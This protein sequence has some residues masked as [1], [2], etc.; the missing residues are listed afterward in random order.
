MPLRHFKHPKDFP[1]GPTLSDISKFWELGPAGLEAFS[2]R[3]G[4]KIFGVLSFISQNSINTQHFK[5]NF[6]HPK[7]LEGIAYP[8]SILRDPAAKQRFKLHKRI[9]PKL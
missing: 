9:G 2:R 5:L 1:P 3:A 8:L 4:A 6:K 7:R